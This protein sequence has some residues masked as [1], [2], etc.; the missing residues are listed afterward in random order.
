MF[1]EQI[2]DVYEVPDGMPLS[3]FN[4]KYSRVKYFV[5][6][7]DYIDSEPE[8]NSN[9]KTVPMYQAW[10]ERVNDVVE[11]NF[12]LDPR[13]S[14]VSHR[15]DFFDMLHTAE[16]G[17]TGSELDA[18]R[19]FRET[20]K[21]SKQGVMAYS[22]RHL[23]HGDRQQREKLGELFTNCSTAMMAWT[24]FLLLLKGSGVGRD[25]SSDICWVD[26]DYMPECRFVLEGPN[27]WGQGGHPDYEPWIES[28]QAAQHKYDSESER[29]RW[30]TVED[31][32]EGWVKI[33]QILETAAFHKNNKDHLFIFDFSQ[34]RAN[35]T[36]IRGQQN[37]PA[38]GPV[39]L[40]QA[41]LKVAS[42]KGAGMRPWKQALFIDDYLASCV[43][44]GGIRRS[45]RMSTKYWKDRDVLEFADIKR[46]G[47]LKSANNSI[48]VDKEFW[49]LVR[50]PNNR[51]PW[52]VHARRVFAAATEAA[53]H[54]NTGEPGFINVDQLTWSDEGIDSITAD[55]YIDHYYANNIVTVH[56]RT[57]EMVSYLLDKAKS[58]KYKVIVNPCFVGETLVAVADGR[59]AVR[60]DELAKSGEVFEVYS[61]SNVGT[62]SSGIKGGGVQISSPWTP[63]IRRARAICSGV[64]SVIR[65]HLS[66][67]DSFD[68]TKDHKLA[69]ASGHWVEASKSEGMYL[70][71]F[72]SFKRKNY[73][74]INSV[75]S[76][77]QHRLIWQFHKGAIPKGYHIDHVNRFE[78]DSIENL[79]M[80]TAK[81][82]YA[83]TAKEF[84]KDNPVHSVDSTHRSNVASKR[85]FLYRN[86]NFSG[87][88]DTD[89]IKIW[90]KAA[91]NLGYIPGI[92]KLLR[93][94][95]EHGGPSS[96]S[97]N[98]FGAWIDLGYMSKYDYICDILTGAVPYSEQ[99]DYTTHVV[100]YKEARVKKSRLQSYE[101]WRYD[102]S[103]SD[104]LTYKGV[105]VIG[106][107]P[108]DK[109]VPVYD[110]QVIV[111]PSEENFDSHSFYII[112]GTKDSDYMT[113]R[114]VLVHNCSEI[115]IAVWGA[116]CTI[117][118]VCGTYARTKDEFKRA[119]ELMARALMR[120]NLMRT[121][122]SA[123]VKRTMRI[124]V[125]MIGIFE[126]AWNHFQINLHEILL[127]DLP[128]DHPKVVKALAESPDVY[129]RSLQFAAF[130]NECGRA[131][132]KSA[133]DY[134]AEI[135]V[136]VPH[137]FLT[138][139][140]AGTAAKVMT[141]TEA[142]NAP[143]NNFYLRNNQ[144][145]LDDPQYHALVKRGYPARDISHAYPGHH[146]IG[147][148]TKQQISDIMGDKVVVAAELTPEDQYSWLRWLEKHWLGGIGRNGQ[149][150]YTMKYYPDQVSYTDF[151]KLLIDHQ[152]TI[153]CC[154]WMQ[155]MDMSKFAYQPEEPITE[156]QYIAYM[157]NIDKVAIEQYDESELQCASGVCPIEKDQLVFTDGSNVVA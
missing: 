105:C 28:L 129:E 81:K 40:I 7:P 138:L 112:T 15:E 46:E 29:V 76:R 139:K 59:N 55:N 53:Y 113:S 92:K 20:L 11:G 63:V 131:A 148:P 102:V 58:K 35:G 22:G 150:S 75:S 37:R 155:I 86:G 2:R 12:S 123:E 16:L 9:P 62:K 140:P 31:S 96:L 99:E 103:N 51:D 57:R 60:I 136:N 21:L 50:N 3:V 48:L 151:Q 117:G 144:Y 111:D 82:H 69:T 43:A 49:D 118:D 127:A 17:H 52:A 13:L 61:A 8:S 70:E 5:P 4:N 142:A 73:R 116:Y 98:R 141:S 56:K 110:V 124:G 10:G 64:K 27:Q 30:F 126:F 109:K 23:Q 97:K 66:N 133:T 68:C 94:S 80:L 100:T 104:D 32:A 154:S 115:P 38:S 33:I 122:Y 120:V 54:D 14:A 135:G 128:K 114:G 146:I 77:K 132:E 42:I 25:Y 18:F 65:V 143:A 87:I 71:A 89:L 26:W 83:K 91:K 39:P 90:R 107:E 157:A 45:A 153:R 85:G 149:V 108:L 137:T 6:N 134:A 93:I 147:F 19:E 44:V 74:C 121:M 1:I 106:I 101:D 84:S 152:S 88:T 67:G 95:Y 145:A 36:P 24:T 125:G 130:I 34:V 78:S 72:A 119:C 47:F 79:Q 156:D 41:L